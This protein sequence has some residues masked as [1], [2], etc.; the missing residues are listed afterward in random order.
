MGSAFR[1]RAYCG[2]GAMLAGE[3]KVTQREGGRQL[4]DESSRSKM[5]WFQQLCWCIFLGVGNVITQLSFSIICP[6]PDTP[7]LGNHF[8]VNKSLF[9]FSFSFS[10]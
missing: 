7:I 10:F 5:G 9:F 8:L 6:L 2:G 4:G 3:L 1:R